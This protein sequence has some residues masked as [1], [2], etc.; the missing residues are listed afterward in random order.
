[1]G[2]VFL[3]MVASH[4]TP[5]DSFNRWEAGQVLAK[6]LLRALYAAAKDSNAVRRCRLAG[7]ACNRCGPVCCPLDLVHTNEIG[8]AVHLHIRNLAWL[9]FPPIEAEWVYS[10]P[11]L[12]CRALSM[13]GWQ[14]QAASRAA[15]WRHSARSST[16]SACEP[17]AALLIV[18]S[19]G[20]TAC[21]A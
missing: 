14:Q 6:K 13:S 10:A 20:L 7:C 17:A 18:H 2:T 1:M 21:H 12:Q 5:A 15:L 19:S 9:A 8:S 4:S 16:V 3:N 11:C